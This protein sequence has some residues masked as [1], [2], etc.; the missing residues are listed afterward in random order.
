[1]LASLTQEAGYSSSSAVNVEDVPPPKLLLKYPPLAYILNTYLHLFNFLKDFPLT[2]TYDSI[3]KALQQHFHSLVKYLIDHSSAIRDRGAKYFGEGYMSNLGVTRPKPVGSNAGNKEGPKVV[4][5][6]DLLYS[7]AIAFTLLPHI[8]FCM[9]ICF[10]RVTPVAL[11]AYLSRFQQI[12]AQIM[13]SY[14]TSTSRRDTTTEDKPILKDL[15]LAKELFGPIITAQMDEFWKDLA[16]AKLV[17]KVVVAAAPERKL[18]FAKPIIS[19]S[20][21]HVSKDVTAVA[22][23]NEEDSEV[24]TMTSEATVEGENSFKSVTESNQSEEDINDP[25]DKSD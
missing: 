8:Y 3:Q 23:E 4:D 18:N 6:M 21:T 25:K 2:T 11:K 12:N 20:T 24:K 7:N 14:N 13:Q 19:V 16:E 1:M 10:Q 15:Q 22:K 9:E 17:D 5:K